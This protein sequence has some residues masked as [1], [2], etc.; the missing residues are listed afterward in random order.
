MKHLYSIICSIIIIFASCSNK[1]HLSSFIDEDHIVFNEK[2][3]K[4]AEDHL[5][6]VYDPVSIVRTLFPFH[7]TEGKSRL[8]IEQVMDSQDFTTIILTHEGILDDSVSGE[9][10]IIEL[11]RINGQWKIISIKLGFKCW[12]NRGHTYYSGELCS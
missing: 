10:R 7:K 12:E 2:I 4:A 9:K 5:D 6:W 1:D 11:K 3:T 8:I